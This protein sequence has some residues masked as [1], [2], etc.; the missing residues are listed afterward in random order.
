MW[1]RVALF[2]S[3]LTAL[4][5]GMSAWTLGSRGHPFVLPLDD[6]Y[7]PLQYARTAA[8]G[9][10]GAYFH[11]GP[12]TVG[13]TSPLWVGVLTVVAFV[14]RGVGA[15]A[16]GVLPVAALWACAAALALAFWLMLRL[17]RGLGVYGAWAVA[18][19]V[20]AV[21]TP[22]WLFGAMNGMETG[23]HAAGLLAGA[24]VLA[25]GSLAWLV[26]LALV[27]PEGAVFA[28]GI[29]GWRL[30]RGRGTS[31]NHG[32][33]VSANH[34]RGLL[35]SLLVLLAATTT[36]AL[37]WILTH[38]ASP[39]WTAKA[40]CLE[41]KAEVRDFY[42]PR[43]PYFAGR[44]LWFGLSG[45]RSQPALDLSSVF[46]KPEA[47]AAWATAGF[48]GAGVVL[49]FFRRR[50]RGLVV[51]W[52]LASLS[53]LLA[54]AW[55]AQFYRYL[56]P[57]Y[58][59][60]LVAATVGWF[61]GDP[62]GPAS[63]GRVEET[64]VPRQT[65]HFLHFLAGAILFALAVLGAFAAP[66]G[67]GTTVRRL[68]RGECERI[69]STQ[70]RVG[71]W[72]AEN[73]PAGARVA[74]HDVGAIAFA[75][76]RPV[77]DLVGLVTPALVGAYRAGEGALWE[78][79]DSLPAEERPA[80]AAVIP[81]WMPYLT[82]TGIF[83]ERVFALEQARTDRSPVSRTFE[84][85]RLSWPSEDRTRWPEGDFANEPRFHGPRGPWASWRVVDRVDVADLASERA[86]AYADS[87]ESGETVIR[88]LGFAL[89]PEQDRAAAMDGGRDVN[90]PARFT[91]RAQPGAPAMLVL[92]TTSVKSTQL[93]VRIGDWT[94]TML[95]PWGESAFREATVLI[96]GHVT[97]RA[98]N[99]V[100]EV[101]VSAAE[102]RAFHWWLLQGGPED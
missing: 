26:P 63:P 48:L 11:D 102:Y 7:I 13:A 20:L 57:A 45:A 33:R 62:R 58:P 64:P 40:L 89:I 95:F 31:A 54:V 101:R 8:G 98:P 1:P 41:P 88:E 74:T 44:C 59:L 30:L 28:I 53:A 4:V 80:Y 71:G 17:A 16:S 51:L 32:S 37:P 46:L 34:S 52:I 70:L 39:S 65:P 55:D 50:G 18:P 27:R 56:V 86:H 83:G 79:L 6:A 9:C 19:L 60:L 3:V 69:E 36:L 82:R 49:T 78:A 100:L 67:V 23:A 76:E 10:P 99:G 94:G 72:I 90:G 25:G 77:V 73:L 42:L 75:G 61:G 97:D 15:N 84:V 66:R 87:G 5:L 12:P 81:A 92:R 2:A 38:Q 93:D 21:I 47:W 35:V 29:F 43:L 22:L 96:P 91:L 68:Y 14:T 85:W 24:W